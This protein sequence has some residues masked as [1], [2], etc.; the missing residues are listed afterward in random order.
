MLV[1][2]D[3]GPTL[4]QYPSSLPMYFCSQRDNELIRDLRLG[5][6]L[7]ST[8]KEIGQIPFDG[9]ELLALMKSLDAKSTF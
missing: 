7:V 4:F 5:V 1:W 9:N 3:H 6:E 2:I 8:M